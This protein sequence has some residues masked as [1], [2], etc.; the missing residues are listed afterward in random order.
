MWGDVDQAEV[1][2]VWAES[3]GR[4]V[5]DDLRKALEVMPGTYKAYPPTLP[6][7]VELCADARRARA[8]SALK[9]DGPRTPMP[10]HIREQLRAFVKTK[11][12]NG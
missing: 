10:G 7:F 4:F 11:T 1:R 8:A 5:A 2:Q 6:Q 9:L 3:L 12:V